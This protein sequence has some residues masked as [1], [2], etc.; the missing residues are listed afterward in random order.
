MTCWG[1]GSGNVL[2]SYNKP[3]RVKLRSK[4]RRVAYATGELHQLV[5][6][7]QSVGKRE[8][9]GVIERDEIRA[10]FTSEFSKIVPYCVY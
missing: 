4:I 3:R 10:L 9:K 5:A 7:T 8:L 2:H 1:W 6:D